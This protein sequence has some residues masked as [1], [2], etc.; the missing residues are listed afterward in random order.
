MKKK[1]DT[2]SMNF[3]M[4]I[5]LHFEKE[6]EDEIFA[7]IFNHITYYTVLT[8]QGNRFFT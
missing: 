3:V 5:I 6:I 1:K 7:M 8:V 2:I 4:I